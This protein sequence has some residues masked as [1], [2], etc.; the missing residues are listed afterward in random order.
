MPTANA[1]TR[2]PASLPIYTG[3][4]EPL[5]ISE[6][7]TLQFAVAHPVICGPGIA[8]QLLFLSQAS[9]V[10]P[11]RRGFEPSHWVL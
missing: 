1:P 11:F 8:L 5:H 10:K 6:H 2:T 9:T 7:D 4:H 3:P